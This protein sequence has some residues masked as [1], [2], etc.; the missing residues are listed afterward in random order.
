MIILK[1]VT[2]LAVW[3]PEMSQSFRK[4]VLI[5]ISSPQEHTGHEQFR[6]FDP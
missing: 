2:T 3:R 1:L 6:S 5:A 4:P